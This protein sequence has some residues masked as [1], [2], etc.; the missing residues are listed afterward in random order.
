MG[1]PRALRA[2]LAGVAIGMLGSGVAAGDATPRPPPPDPDPDPALLEFLGSVDGLAEV[3]P[4][5]LA[6]V[7]RAPVPRPSV[8]GSTEPAP[9]PPAPPP[10]G[11]TGV[12]K[13]E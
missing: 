4:N 3:N 8:R 5:Y 7:K 9:S 12:K 10:P 13:N 2:M 11:P 6:Q 1:V